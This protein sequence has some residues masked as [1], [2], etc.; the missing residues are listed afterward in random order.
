MS[1]PRH[2]IKA[3]FDYWT[4]IENLAIKT[5]ENAFLDCEFIEKVAL[6]FAGQNRALADEAVRQLIAKGILIPLGMREEYQIHSACKEFIL[7]LSQEHDLGLAESIRVEVQEMQRLG[8]LIQNAISQKDLSGLQNPLNLLGRRIQAIQKQLEHD[9]LAILNIADKAKTL[10]QDTPLSVRYREV[11]ESFD[12]YVEPMIQLLQHDSSGFATLTENIE[13]Q[14]IVAETLCEQ[15]G[16]LMS[17][18]RKISVNARLLRTLR[19]E[20]RETLSLCRETLMPLREEYLKNSRLAIAVAKVLAVVRKK[21]MGPILGRKKIILGGLSRTSRVIPGRFAK[22]YMADVLNFKAQVVDFPDHDIDIP[23]FESILRFE[24][25]LQNFEQ[26]VD[27]QDLR[28]DLDILTWLLQH[29]PEQSEK[30]LLKVYHQLVRHFPTQ[31]TH[32]DTEKKVKL[33]QHFL[34]LYPHIFRV[35]PKNNK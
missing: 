9:K 10:P 3:L 31:M 30:N 13:D 14:L 4:I 8:D 35:V 2:L 16:A 17:W 32:S 1:T 15:L 18:K 12:H 21:G 11:I 26:F 23:T 33:P 34:Q 27:S 5:K 7:S 25:V 29:Y 22:A 19:A 20:A 24:D 6:V 28:D